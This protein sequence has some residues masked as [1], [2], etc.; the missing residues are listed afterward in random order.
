MSALVLLIAHELP[1]SG[2]SPAKPGPLPLVSFD[3][4]SVA[5]VSLPKP[6]RLVGSPHATRATTA[7]TK[8][9]P[10][11]SIRTFIEASQTSR[12]GP[13]GEPRPTTKSRQLHPMDE[14]PSR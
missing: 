8:H 4:G 14:N 2:V 13:N 1:P 5:S 12:D 11:Q 7:A 6:L 10:V 3:A 9:P